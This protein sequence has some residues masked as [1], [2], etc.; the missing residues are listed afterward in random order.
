MLRV[1]RAETRGRGRPVAH[2]DPAH[3]RTEQVGTSSRIA[4]T[5]RCVSRVA[6]RSPGGG[7]ASASAGVPAGSDTSAVAEA[8]PGTSSATANAAALAAASSRNDSV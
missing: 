3:V 5:V 8:R 1:C 2:G 4:L 6:G 7:Y